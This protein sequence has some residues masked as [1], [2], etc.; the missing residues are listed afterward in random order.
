[1]SKKKISFI[2]CTLFFS[3]TYSQI[4]SVADIDN[5]YKEYINLRKQ[6]K[7]DDEILLYKK[8]IKKSE[9]INYQEGIARGNLKIGDVLWLKG[10]FDESLDFI[11]IAEQN[12]SKLDNA[13][14]LS[15]FI[16]IALAKNYYSLKLYDKSL[17]QSWKANAIGKRIN[18]K[19][20]RNNLLHQVNANKLSIYTKLGDM[21]SVRHLTLA[22]FRLFSDKNRPI[23]HYCNLSD[24]YLLINKIDSAKYYLDV[25][26]VKASKKKY[27]NYQTFALYQTL[28]DY[29][30][31]KKEYQS[32][33]NSYN[34]ALENAKTLQNNELVSDLY[35]KIYETSDKEG[36][37]LHS[38]EFLRKFT[39][40]NE[41]ASAIFRKGWTKSVENFIEEKEKESAEKINR[42]NFINIILSTTVVFL[43]I[44]AYRIKR[45]KKRL[46]RAKEFEKQTII[47][48]KNKEVGLL[49]QKVNES[50]DDVIYLAKENHPEF[51]SRFREVYPN[52]TVKILNINSNLNISEL[53]FCA[54]IFLNFSTKDIA[55]YTF[56]SPRT[57]QTRK[58]NLRKKLNMKSHENFYLWV[59]NNLS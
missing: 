28:G 51:F 45:R 41:A 35:R 21:D 17:K 34:I 15:A 19:T 1:M 27:S 39:E 7:L 6:N 32:A 29:H 18:D 37:I 47:S 14:E 11:R 13:S 38:N 50:F 31:A 43:V 2:L 55:E 42:T 49:L 48:E 12:V 10:R 44:Y 25:A 3:Y 33:L 58:Y 16:C 52:F 59:Q 23:L 22:N 20:A 53:T 40:T 9:E 46:I 54:Y 56:T 5:S 30:V 24:Y 57:V 4:N 8:L 36:N 26:M